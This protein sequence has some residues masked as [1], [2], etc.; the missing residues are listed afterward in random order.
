ML[1]QKH[2]LECLAFVYRPV[3]WISYNG[4]LYFSPKTAAQ[5]EQIAAMKEARSRY[6]VFTDREERHQLAAQALAESGLDD[7]WQKKLLLP[8]STTNQNLTPTLDRPLRIL[9]KF[10]RLEALAAGDALIEDEAGQVYFVMDFGRGAN[11]ATGTNALLIKEGMK[12]YTTPA[13]AYKLVEAFT[14]ASLSPEETA[15]LKRAAAA[16][17]K[18]AAALNSRLKDTREFE[19]LRLRATDTN[20]YMQYLLAKSYLEGNGTIKSEQLGLE[21]MKRAAKNGSGDASAWLASRDETP[22]K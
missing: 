11:D 4:G 18:K 14:S 5:D 3:L 19:D 21:W 20:P 7:S 17:H 16:F 15:I 13:G 22:K 1:E 2:F 12:T 10:K 9:P 8:Y 6:Q